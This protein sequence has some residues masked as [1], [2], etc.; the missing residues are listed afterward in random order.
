[1]WQYHA[2][3]ALYLVI[4]PDELTAIYFALKNATG[5]GGWC[6]DNAPP[7]AFDF[8]LCQQT[9]RLQN[10]T[11][12]Y[13]ARMLL[14]SNNEKELEPMQARFLALFQLMLCQVFAKSSNGCK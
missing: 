6:I 9:T 11:A 5:A 1:M 14:K 4:L 3:T 7:L 10:F 8:R 12:L 2:W 13:I